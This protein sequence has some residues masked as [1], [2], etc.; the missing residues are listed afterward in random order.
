MIQNYFKTAYRSL[1]K[2]KTFSFINIVGLAL[3]MTVV[4]LISL[5][6]QNEKSYDQWIE[7]KENIYRTYRQWGPDG[8]TVYT[9]DPLVRMLGSE[10][11]DV[12]VSAGLNPFGETLL[13]YKGKKLYVENAALVDSS[14]FQLFKFPVV[15][16]NLESTLLG[17]DDLV[18]SS[19]VAKNLFGEIDP[20]G[21]LVNFRDDPHKV[22]GVFDLGKQNTHLNYDIYVKGWVNPNW[23]GNNKATY[24]KLKPGTSIPDFESKMTKAANKYVGADLDAINYAYKQDELS[25]WKLQ[26]VEQVYLYSS[27]FMWNGQEGNI[28]YVNIFMLIALL[29]MIVAIINY[30][31]LS[32]AQAT[33]RAKEVGVRKTSGATRQQLI[34]QFLTESLLQ[35]LC[36]AVLAIV[37]AESLLPLFNGIV[38]RELS[39][40]GSNLIWK[41]LSLLLGFSVLVGLLAGIYPAFVL[42]NFRPAK[43]LKGSLLAGS[44]KTGLRKF[45]VSSQFAVSIG[46]IVVMTFIFQQVQFMIKHDLGFNPEQVMVIPINE[47]TTHRTIDNLKSNFLSIPGVTSVTT[48]SDM[49]GQ[50]F[51]DWGMNIQGEEESV[52]PNVLFT[53]GDCQNTF[54]LDLVDGRFLSNDIANDTLSNFVVNETFV[55]RYKIENPIGHPIKFMFDENYGQIVGVVKDFHF[56]GLQNNIRPLAMTGR[57]D[58]WYGFV[59]LSTS[60]L[61]ETIGAIEALWNQE[62]EPVYPMRYSFLDERFQEQY[63][64]QE[65]FGTAMLS[66]TILTLLIAILGLFGLTTFAVERRLKEIGIRKV[67]GASVGSIIG[68]FSKDFLKLVLIAFIVAVPLSYYLTDQWLTD[69]AYRIDLKWWVFLVAGIV[70]AFITILT[71]GLQSTKAALSNPIKSLRTE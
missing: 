65:R 70:A 30:V 21:K 32:T 67:L 1:L 52:N 39:L 44:E 55:K 59:K 45:L 6:V 42:S 50:Q 54:G 34:T 24:V 61:K 47:R 13:E 9:P 36:A 33:K 35:T 23:T 71:V 40:I 43:V 18:L 38:D 10:F 56:R 7:G 26:P 14:F 48:A 31:N 68:L 51:S 2:N 15:N 62:I 57:H 19:T 5:F 41:A 27:N 63:A 46:L 20:I 49:P 22:I 17:E 29:V 4:I 58:R 60:N 11:P 69:F 28:R 66:A 25:K 8:N 37:I 16:G 53:D 12:E 64:E 3:G